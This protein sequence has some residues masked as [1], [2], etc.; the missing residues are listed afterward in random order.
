[1]KHRRVLIHM[2]ENI[3]NVYKR[4]V[5]K[6]FGR[7]KIARKFEQTFQIS[8]FICMFYFLTYK[9]HRESCVRGQKID[10]E[11]C[12]WY[13]IW[14]VIWGL[15]SEWWPSVIARMCR[16]YFFIHCFESIQKFC[17]GLRQINSI[18]YNAWLR[19]NLIYR[20]FIPFLVPFFKI[21]FG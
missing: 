13:V 6:F 14:S 4:K 8:F 18:L 20:T 10:V 3:K 7:V 5:F 21:T 12:C 1:M 2:N 16:K 11:F 17:F 19:Q 15:L 9:W